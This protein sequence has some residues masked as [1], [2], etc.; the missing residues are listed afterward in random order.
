MKRA[1]LINLICSLI[2]VVVIIIGILV[3]MIFNGIIAVEKETLVIS[4]SSAIGTYNGEELTDNGWNL[5]EGELRDGHTLSVNVSGSQTGVG[6]S[7]N[8]VSAKVFDENGVDVS[9]EYNISYR[10]GALNV[11][12][13]TLTVIAGSDMKLYDGEPIT[14]GDYTVEPRIA[15]VNGDVIEVS[16]EGSLTDIGEADNNIAEVVIRNSQGVDVTRNYNVKTVKGKLIVYSA[17][18]LVIES[19][20][21]FKNYD[22]I[23]LTNNNWKIVSGEL[24]QD[25]NIQVNMTGTITNAGTVDNTFDVTVVDSSNKDVT[26]SYNIISNFGKLTVIK[27]RVTIESL[28]A[29]K[30]Y[31]GTPLVKKEFTV[32]P[33]NVANGAFE[34][35]PLITGSRTEIGSSPN[36]IESCIVLNN[37]GRDVTD[38]FEIEYVAGNLTVTEAPVVKTDIT[39]NS[40]DAS[41]TYDGAPLT[42]A[43]WRITS[44]ELLDGHIADVKVTGTITDRGSVDNAMTVVIRDSAGAD[45]SSSY[46]ITKNLGVLTIRAIEV[47]VISNSAEKKYDG[48]PLTDSG[49]EVSPAYI[50]KDFA[51]DVGVVGSRTEVGVSKNTISY[52]NVTNASGEDVSKNFDIV[53]Q[54]GILEVLEP[55]KDPL[56]ELVYRSGSASRNY[57]G[58]PLTN[59]VCEL[60]E[61]EL[62]EG[63]RAEIQMPSSI[64]DFGRV[65][66]EII[67][68]IFDA[69]GNDV[70][71]GYVIRKIKGTLEITRIKVTVSTASDSKIYDGRPLVNGN[72]DVSPEL[73]FMEG[74]SLIIDINGIQIEPGESENTVSFCQVVDLEGNEV[75]EFYDIEFEYGSLIV[76]E[77]E[78]PT[79]EEP[80][81]PEGSEA[82][83]VGPSGSSTNISGPSLPLN[84]ATV[85]KV[86]SSIN[87]YLYLKETSYGDYKSTK[88]GW[89]SAPVY[90]SRLSN[91]TCAFFLPTQALLNSGKSTNSCLIKPLIDIYVLP[92]YSSGS[93]IYDSDD[94]RVAGDTSGEY[95]VEYYD[96]NSTTG[97]RLPS[98]A[99]AFEL[100]YRAFVEA[101][102]LNI[103][104]ET[105][106]Y[107]DGIIAAEKFNKNDSSIINKV[108]SYIKKSAKY[109]LEYN[110]EL[111]N[112]ENVVVS[113]LSEYKQGICQHY[114]SAATLLFRAL[115]IPARYT[116][117]FVV[118]TVAGKEVKVP[119]S[120]AH[121]W[122][123]VYV[124]G[125]GW[126]N[127]EVTGSS[128]SEIITLEL[129]PINQGRVYNGE[130]LYVSQSVN[131]ASQLGEK[132]YTY[133]AVVDGYV[134]ELGK[135]ET[136]IVEFR[137][138]DSEGNLVYDKTAGIGKDK[139]SISY[140][141]GQIHQ[142]LSTLTFASESHQMTYDGSALALDVSECVLVSGTLFEGYTYKITDPKSIYKAG[143]AIS[144][145]TVSIYKDGE[146]C[147]D[148]Y[149]IVKN[150]GTL[151][152]FK[153]EITMIAGSMT[154]EWDGTPLEYNHVYY[155][156][157]LLANGDTVFRYTL[158]GSLTNVGKCSNV[159]REVVIRNNKG[160]D[161]TSCYQIEIVD[162]LLT[163]VMPE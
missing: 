63:H 133:E 23:P 114:A 128:E 62:A 95:L 122:V 132:G 139:F 111:D 96:W 129:K 101:N 147:T 151:T 134:E 131:G 66:N 25:H 28:S 93:A 61:G 136:R 138:Y 109:N 82:P 163:V 127:V 48:T 79:P 141:S 140:K 123:E 3:V 113:F 130:P 102:Y 116:V 144:D 10:P 155:D 156:E 74:H 18:T 2:A 7:E 42:R 162:G 126:V 24:M 146:L 15:L 152:I 14:C 67:V 50:N 149:N 86:T 98:S 19:S 29:E 110:R 107:M 71:D 85:Y 44:G 72:Y 143:Q 137:I 154:K 90:N 64:T 115:G 36:T 75:T 118:E 39:F 34:F 120:N 158:S 161:V 8:Y 35:R 117:G 89:E 55:D 13:R 27:Q 12:A 22:G 76:L 69:D 112:E 40:Y 83:L 59:H 9:D 157:T 43:D 105:R 68:T 80:E 87:D 91:G 145:F 121:A 135:A 148:H 54:H 21:D 94:V 119:L 30:Q 26:A 81:E 41:K 124:N 88:D 60:L 51:F 38:N 65:D 153:K 45:V 16:V 77:A 56:P 58:L 150:C 53:N 46:N 97:I 52:C 5:L 106:N 17:D 84:N 32:S 142:Y 4:S 49:F 6:V 125:I 31:D 100:E 103:D 73:S 104:E 33:K 47:T 1:G 37:Y 92:Y 78:E 57:N 159:I 70:T 11:K 20:S 99:R 108:A 160:E